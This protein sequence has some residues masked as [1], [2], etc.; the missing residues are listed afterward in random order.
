MKIAMVYIYPLDGQGEHGVKAARFIDSY[1]RNPPGMAHD[2]VVVCN[3]GKAS[4][5]TQQRF[6]FLPNVQLIEGN[7]R[8]KDIGGFLEAAKTVK[9]DLMLFFGGAAY[10]RKPEWMVPVMRSYFRKGDTLYGACGHPGEGDHIHPHIRTTG[11][12]LRPELLTQYCPEG[13]D[14]DRRYEFEH[15]ASCLTNWIK[16][17][18]ITPWVVTYAGEHSLHKCNEIPGGYHNGD[19]S[20]VVFGDRLTEPPNWDDP[21]SKG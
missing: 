14:N 9:A 7:N 6:S 8:G 17:R 13:I 20:N 2:T 16:N 21:L 19:Q 10:F 11:F 5:E 12:W 1:R 4:S 18:G 3:G 15:G